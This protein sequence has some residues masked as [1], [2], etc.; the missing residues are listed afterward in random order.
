[1]CVGKSEMQDREQIQK[2]IDAVKLQLSIA[3]MSAITASEDE[4]EHWD[5]RR[6]S[7]QLRLAA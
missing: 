1:M 2:E 7:L 4:K 6:E 5:K 3:D